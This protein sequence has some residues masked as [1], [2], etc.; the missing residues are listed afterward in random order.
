MAR[1]FRSLFSCCLCDYLF[2]SCST[3]LWNVACLVSDTLFRAIK[4][5]SRML[6]LR[7]NEREPP[8]ASF[9]PQRFL[10]VLCQISYTRTR[11]RTHAHAH[12]RG[13]MA[14]VSLAVNQLRTH[15]LTRTHNV[16]DS[17]SSSHAPFSLARAHSICFVRVTTR[18]DTNTFSRVFFFAIAFDLALCY[19]AQALFHTYQRRFR[20]GARGDG[21]L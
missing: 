17:S 4:L 15:T 8:S 16:C 21:A 6:L 19:C 12:A 7:R 3:H 11:T 13:V 1:L 5:M 20:A 2:V 18:Q 9:T 14:R 10:S